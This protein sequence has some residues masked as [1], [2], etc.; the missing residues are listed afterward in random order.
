MSGD[1]SKT[2]ISPSLFT[3]AGT[4]VASSLERAAVAGKPPVAVVGVS[5]ADVV[6]S[7]L[8]TTMGTHITAASA[9]MAPRGPKMREASGAAAAEIQAQDVKNAEDIKRRTMLKEGYDNIVKEFPG[10]AQGAPTPPDIHS[11]PGVPD[12]PK[13]PWWKLDVSADDW[14]MTGV[15]TAISAKTDIP[16][17]FVKTAT[18]NLAKGEPG[19][20]AKT[21]FNDIKGLKGVTPASTVL[22]V[23][24]VVWQIS[25]DMA[26]DPAM[27]IYQ[28]TAKEGGGFLAGAAAGALIGSAIPIP[29]VG[30]VTGLLLGGAIGMG[31]G[32]YID[33]AWEPAANAVGKVLDFF[34]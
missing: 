19:H 10:A 16:G 29:V 30:T 26:E 14:A 8:A 11:G 7:G 9:E 6:A 31:A 32:E 2:D 27:S 28:A 12:A 3:E 4:T 15:G 22:G 18:E 17:E 23:P 24:F 21:A 25:K 33:K 20:W 34:S 1:G 5:P 13:Q